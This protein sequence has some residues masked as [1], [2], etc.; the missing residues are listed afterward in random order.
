MIPNGP[1][2]NMFPYTN[3]HSMNLDW[4]IQVAK[5]FLDQYTNIQQTITDGLDALD[6]KKEALEA[7]LQ[8]WYDEHSQDIADQLADALA[9]LNAWYTL[10]EGYL[11]ATLASNTALFN[12][13]AEAKAE[14]TLE[15]IPADYT[16][17]SNSVNDAAVITETNLSMIGYGIQLVNPL[18]TDYHADKYWNASGGLSNADSTYVAYSIPVSQGER[19]CANYY[20]DYTYFYN[21]STSEVTPVTL[22]YYTHYYETDLGEIA[23]PADVTHLLATMANTSTCLPILFKV[24]NQYYYK[25]DNFKVAYGKPVINYPTMDNRFKGQ[26]YYS[27][28]DSITYYD[29][30][31]YIETTD[32]AGSKCQGYQTYIQAVTG[33]DSYNHGINGADSGQILTEVQNTDV[34]DAAL[35]TIMTGVNDFARSISVDTFKQNLREM[36]YKIQ[37]QNPR[38][39]LVLLSNTFGHFD[40]YGYVTRTYADAMKEIAVEGNHP[41]IDNMQDNGINANNL[42]RYMADLPATTYAIHPNCDGFARIGKQIANKIL[43]LMV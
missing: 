16:S 36:I 37:V 12:Q 3:F 24:Y 7:L 9:D 41:F 2:G 10:H 27:F 8:A 42:S 26:K 18:S 30:H 15:S 23:I 29:K 20:P 22:Q 40:Q 34:S 14:Q 1:F 39:M 21:E 4:V 28:G 33:F 35:V 17:L 19:Y 13:R 32:V 38:C 5:D 31:D 43:Q 6:A 25:P 11:D